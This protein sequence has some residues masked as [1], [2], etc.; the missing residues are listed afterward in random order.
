MSNEPIVH[1]VDDDDGVR[2]SLSLLLE[3]NGYGIRTF[4]SGDQFLQELSTI[5]P[6]C[7]LLDI[8]MPGRSG[9]EVLRA[10][11]EQHSPLPIVMMTGQGDIGM[12]VSA[13][14]AGASDFIEK[15]FSTKQILSA[16][17]NAIRVMENSG[18]EQEK[19]EAARAKIASLSRREFQVL[20]GLLAALTNK[21]IAYE[22]GISIRTVEVYRANIMDKLE[23]KGLS[24]AVRIAL[25]AGVEALGE[26]AASPD[27]PE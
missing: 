7:I 8:H 26:T 1:I 13:M 16:I 12:A 2:E 23:A 14:K 5:E 9:L 15:P 18:E 22:L 6:G 3:M 19:T 20:Q 11:L 25:L 24:V 21:L 4:P 10:L 17:G 27:A